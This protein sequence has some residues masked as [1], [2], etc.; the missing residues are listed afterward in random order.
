MCTRAQKY[1]SLLFADV[2]ECAEGTAN[3]QANSYCVN[4]DNGY[5]CQCNTGYVANG[6]VCIDV[7]ECASDSDNECHATLGTCTNLEGTYR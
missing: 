2:D 1:F 3:C 6:N 5:S 4:T 7:D